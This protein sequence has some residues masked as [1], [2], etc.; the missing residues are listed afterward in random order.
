MKKKIKQLFAPIII[1]ILLIITQLIYAFMFLKT[2]EFHITLF[3][4][5]EAFIIGGIIVSIFV[6]IERIREIYKGE[7]DDLSKY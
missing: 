7:C 3:I 6:L 4:F 1:T 5:L 2:R